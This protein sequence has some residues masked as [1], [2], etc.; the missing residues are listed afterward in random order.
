MIIRQ[1]L[2]ISIVIF[3]CGCAREKNR[4]FILNERDLIPEGTS[5]NEEKELLYIGCIYKQKIIGINKRGEESVVIPSDQFGKYSPLGIFY[6]ARSEKIW[7]CVA[8]APIVNHENDGRWETT[9]HTF[10]PKTGTIIKEYKRLSD[11]RPMLLNDLTVTDDGTVYITESTHNR[12]Y[13]ITENADSLELFFELKQI[14]FPNGITHR[15]DNLFIASD[16]GIAK[17]NL[18]SKSIELINAHSGVDATVIDG[19]EIHDNYFIGHQSTRVMRF[20]FDE[21]M[22]S[23]THSEILDHGKEFDSSTTGVVFGKD[24]YFI[25]NSQLRSGIDQSVKR[26]KPLDSLEKVIIRKLRL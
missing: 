1:F 8:M 4:D 7:S 5:Y 17:L 16:Q 21:E 2:A 20:Y 9:I 26:V 13:R 24:Y 6:D 19:L 15:D 3:I 18:L 22:T 11:S 23:L 14:K 10:D 25:V 12:I